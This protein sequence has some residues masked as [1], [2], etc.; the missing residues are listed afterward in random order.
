MKIILG[1]LGGMVGFFIVLHLINFLFFHKSSAQIAKEK[2]ASIQ[3]V[4]DIYAPEADSL[5]VVDGKHVTC[6]ELL[7]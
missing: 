2:C 1:I 3:K 7:K 6:K 4:L 5:T